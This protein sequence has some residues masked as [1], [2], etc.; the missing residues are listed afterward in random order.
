MIERY[1]RPE[2]TAIWT[3]QRKYETW[4]QV[5]LAASDA[6]VKTGQVPQAAVDEIREK[7]EID[8]ARIDELEAVVKHDVIAF[9][10]SI[11]EK[12]G[13]AGRFIHM[14]MTS[15][16]V[17]DTALALLLREAADILIA[18]LEALLQALKTQALKHKKTLMI[19]RSHGIH[20]EP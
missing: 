18:D 12:V 11:T 8:V 3:Q 15:S 14:G 10:T 7:A 13:E 5:E 9:L 4:L 20:G 6:L 17:L 19:G 2:M 1:A 16:D